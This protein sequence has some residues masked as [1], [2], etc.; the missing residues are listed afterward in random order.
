MLIE[1]ALAVGFR[2]TT[3]TRCSCSATTPRHY[4]HVFASDDASTCVQLRQPLFRRCDARSTLRRSS[5]IRA[6]AK[7]STS[8][9][10]EASGKQSYTYHPFEEIHE[11]RSDGGDDATLTSSETARTLI[12]VN[13]QATL[14]L[15]GLINDE[16]H[17][18]IFWPDLP[19][20]TD[21][22]G[23]E[24]RE[25]LSLSFFQVII[26]MD[27]T[28]ML[29]EME[30]GQGDIDFGFE[31][32]VEDENEDDEEEEGDEDEEDEEEDSDYENDWVGALD[33]EED[34]FDSDGTIGDWAKLE[35][36]RSSHPMY[37]AKKLTEVA[38]EKPLD[39][40]DQPPAG[41]VIQGL[42][43]PAFVDE[44]T[45]I[46]KH[47]SDP[48]SSDESSQI[49]KVVD[50]NREEL[51]I[52][53]QGNKLDSKSS[54]KD[55]SNWAEEMEKDESLRTGSSFYKLEMIKIQ[56]TVVEVKD[57]L[58]SQPDAIA[59]SSAKIL[60]RLKAGGEKTSQAL[61]SLCW[62][63]K[64][65]QVEEVAPIGLD[66]LGLDLRVCSGA[67]I[68][69]LRFGFQKRSVI[70]MNDESVNAKIDVIVAIMS[71]LDF[72]DNKQVMLNRL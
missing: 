8:D 27:T 15:S 37:F 61:M 51:H 1:S 12:E 38:A 48:Q 4:R 29:N 59:H 55:G 45:V 44:H 40:M 46:R 39:W 43:R 64:G 2:G 16:V 47:V 58:R 50:D 65:I 36:M 5:R 70:Y 10:S 68:Q 49:G 19:Y 23:S 32:I 66:S 63:V 54:S 20:L 53:G 21:E 18:N 30:L 22:H 34:G 25:S 28:E 31:D 3:A 69:T 9:P 41:L 72:T 33:H 42:L 71:V 6:V 14:M 26:G 24:Y 60:S 56:L 67:Q 7:D 52:N 13:G 62:R 35:T 57:F 11:T 17:E